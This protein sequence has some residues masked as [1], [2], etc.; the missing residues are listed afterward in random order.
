MVN[1]ESSSRKTLRKVPNIL[2]IVH[3]SLQNLLLCSHLKST[4]ARNFRFLRFDF[5][6]DPILST[7]TGSIPGSEDVDRQAD[8]RTLQ[9]GEARVPPQ[10]GHPVSGRFAR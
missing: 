5:D 6:S 2:G 9:L 3:V 10:V 4:R 8:L 1:E 7:V